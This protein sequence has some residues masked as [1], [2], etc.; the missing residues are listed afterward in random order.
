MSKGSWRR[1]SSV[2]VKVSNDNWERIFSK[3]KKDEVKD[4][5]KESETE[6]REERGKDTTK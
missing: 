6:K 2:P 1:P 4:D 5:K 3:K